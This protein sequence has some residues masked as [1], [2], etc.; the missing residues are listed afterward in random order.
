[1][2]EISF[3]GRVAL[4]TGA[5]RGIGRAHAHQLA[6]RGAS[7]V[8]NDLGGRVDGVGA[9]PEV[10]RSVAEEIVGA[11]GVAIAD[12][13]DVSH[14]A[15]A[16]DAVRAAIREFGRLDVI[17]NN[18]G[19]IAW[20]ALDEVD[21]DTFDR[22]CAVHVAGT[23]NVA[24]AAWPYLAECGHGRIVNTTSSAIFGMSELV[25]YAAAK[26]GV[27]GLTRALARA[28]DPLGI[29]VNAIAPLAHSRMSARLEKTLAAEGVARDLAPD[30]VAAVVAFLAHASCSTTGEVYMAG[31]GAV[32][33]IFLGM[34][35]GYGNRELSAEDVA[36]NWG[37]INDVG[38][39]VVPEDG[40]SATRAL[41]ATTTP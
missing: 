36:A 17:V 25:P 13:S 2:E 8:V 40:A 38:A 26:A 9:D 27:L 41:L 32:A 1:M 35:R 15:G 34:T 3:S 18:A 39:F 28:G 22:H 24:L 19:I 7:V 6:E 16:H 29:G 4:V 23:L 12:G 37:S 10:A 31:G 30:Y 33:R 5:G 21:S 20:V 11:G 14:A